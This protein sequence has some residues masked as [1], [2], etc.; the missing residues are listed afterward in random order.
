MKPL[1]AGG[2]T[3]V[4]SALLLLSACA[5]TTSAA[6]EPDLGPVTR[7]ASAADLA[8][9]LDAYRMS[10]KE[11]ATVRRANWRLV[12]ACVERYGGEYTLEEADT[13]NDVPQFDNLNERRYG[14]LDPA[15]AAARGYN[16]PP[17]LRRRPREKSGWDPSAA[18]ELLVRGVAPRSVEELD[19]ATTTSVPRPT[20]RTGKALPEDGCAGEA[21]RA[22]VGNAPAPGNPNLADELGVKAYKK[23]EA[24][25]RVREAMGRWSEC[26]KRS[27]YTYPDIWAP[28][29][30]TWPEPANDE[31]IATAKADVA[32]KVE[33]NLVG[34][35]FT[36]ET[37]YQRPLMEENAEALAAVQKD[38]RTR[39]ANAARLVSGG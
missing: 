8:L 23:A 24:D 31:E 5:T 34:V 37:A 39:V 27:G 28:N 2:T 25:S 22:L 14:L 32:C 11:Y 7:V 33:S 13:I 38:T 1:L 29:D 19:G 30:K 18:E 17:E 3:L 12:K 36:A 6:A 15:S 20:D 10:G 9:P 26:M 16:P 35:W 4:C 21:E